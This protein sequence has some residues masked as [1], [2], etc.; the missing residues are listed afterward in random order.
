MSFEAVFPRGRDNQVASYNVFVQ[1]WGDF[2]GSPSYNVFKSVAYTRI[3]R[4]I[5][6][7]LRSSIWVVCS[8]T[9]T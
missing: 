6:V 7:L 1:R 8:F 4:P 9:K 3:K 5:Q 2:L